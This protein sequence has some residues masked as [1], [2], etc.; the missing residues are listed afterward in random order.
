MHGGV[1]IRDRIPLELFPFVTDIFVHVVHKPVKKDKAESFSERQVRQ[2]SRSGKFFEH[3]CLTA[4]D[5]DHPLDFRKQHAADAPVVSAL[6]GRKGFTER[7][8]R[9]IVYVIVRET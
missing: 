2:V 4:S 6:M 1:T 3:I 9:F 5:T 7:F 8:P